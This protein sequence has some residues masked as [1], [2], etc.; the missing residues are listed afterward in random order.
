MASFFGTQD[1][2]LY[3]ADNALKYKSLFSSGSIPLSAL[4]GGGGSQPVTVFAENVST[5]IT[6]LRGTQFVAVTTNKLTGNNT[7]FVTA[8]GQ[9]SWTEVPNTTDRFHLKLRCNN[10]N[11]DTVASP[12][13]F[14]ALQDETPGQ[15]FF[16]I[17]GYV[18]PDAD[19]VLHLDLFVSVGDKVGYTLGI[20]EATYTL[21]TAVPEP[22]NPLLPVADYDLNSYTAG[23]ESLINS[24]VGSVYGDA[25]VNVAVMNT[26]YP[27]SP[28]SYLNLYWAPYPEF[29]GGLITPTVSG[30][31]TVELWMR[32][33][34]LNMGGQYL[35][36]FRTGLTNGYIIGAGSGDGSVGAGQVGNTLWV[37]GTP[38][39]LTAVTNFVPLLTDYQWKQ[40][41]L[42]CEVPFDDNMSILLSQANV[43]GTPSEVAQ[44]CVYTTK[45]TAEQ[46]KTVFNAKC[47]R[48]GLAPLP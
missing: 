16:D 25:T 33:T 35:V 9:I 5:P 28:N 20:S 47:S 15:E 38:T 7:Y 40:V 39:V 44:V 3:V 27:G 45:L 43:Q 29:T 1:F 4:G 22:V 42:T 11:A 10:T 14:P 31:Q 6:K 8:K 19:S 36:D 26:F 34:S 12:S 23:S 17:A 41:V 13:V 18:T 24:A 30:I 2:K 48:Y 37:N 32:L 46:I 21:V